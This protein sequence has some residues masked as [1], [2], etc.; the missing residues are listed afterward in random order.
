MNRG[1][2]R[3]GS[4]DRAAALALALAAIVTACG[5]AIPTESP[6]PGD[7]VAS[8]SPS[9]VASGSVVVPSPASVPP[10]GSASPSPSASLASV[11]PSASPTSLIT[12]RPTA[13]PTSGDLSVQLCAKLPVTDVEA[14]L[15][16][17][18]L[19]VRPEPADGG[20]GSCTY[21]SGDRAVAATSWITTGARTVIASF[22]NSAESIPGLA[23]AAIWVDSISTLYIR[24]G[25]G[26]MGIAIAVAGPVARE[27]LR[28]ACIVLG[29]AAAGRL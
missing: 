5:Q 3:R 19:T 24:K 13:T 21:L 16:V 17:S 12:P 26:L 8:A 29:Q 6:V 25:T 28:D 11:A 7:S 23:D 22:G 9:P 18:G 10:S 14:V 4:F 27:D 15:N 20:R 2:G 1:G